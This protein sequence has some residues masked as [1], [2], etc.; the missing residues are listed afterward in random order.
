MGSILVHFKRGRISYFVNQM[1]QNYLSRGKVKQ[2][3]RERGV[4][5]EGGLKVIKSFDILLSDGHMFMQQTPPPKT[6]GRL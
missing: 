4:D 6:K 3:M 2:D 1:H 5:G